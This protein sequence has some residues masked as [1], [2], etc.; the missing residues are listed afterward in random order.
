MR[1][2]IRTKLFLWYLILI[3]IFYGT[4][5][6]LLMQ[7]SKIMQTSGYMVNRNIEIASSKKMIENLLSM[8]ENEKKYILLNKKEYKGYFVSAQKEFET[9]LIKVLQLESKERHGDISWKELYKNYR[10]QLPKPISILGEKVPP[11]SLW[12]PEDVIDNWI[13][14]ISK[15]R[16][17]SE[18]EVEHRILELDHRGQLA[19]RWGFIGLGTSLLVG[20]LGS[21]FLAH[22]MH[23]PLRELTKGIRSIPQRGLRTPIPIFSK[24]EFG[25]LAKAFNEMADRLGQEEQMRSDFI[26]MLSHETRT[27]LTSIRESVNLIADEVMGPISDKQK[28]FLLIASAEI[29]RIT[30]LLNHLMQVSR[31][32]AGVLDVTL[33]P[34]DP[35]PLIS[36]S[37]Y[38]LTPAAE[39]KGVKILTQADALPL[40]MGDP[41]HLQQVLLNLMGNAIKFSSSGSEIV[42][43]AVPDA[44]KGQVKFSVS[45]NGPGIP[46]QEQSFVFQKYYRA[47]GIKDEVDGVGLGLSIS[48]HI[49]EAHGGLIWVQSRVGQGCTFGFSVPTVPE[50]AES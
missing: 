22:T 48:K 40:V 14:R 12:I 19:V 11:K 43:K 29:E 8:E 49:V 25:E 30:E 4:I 3:S 26:S 17:E 20:L 42:V 16:S 31:M 44:I 2:G 37:V 35:L 13:N 34:L 15:L 33:R 6:L 21:M 7:I 1:F 38:R 50:V 27:P 10:A 9:N 36:S 46:E 47:S 23:R 39:A 18:K 41:D 28:R 5:F 32:E 45:D 24:D